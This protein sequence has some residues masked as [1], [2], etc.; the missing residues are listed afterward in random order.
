MNLGAD[1]Q[2]TGVST[3]RIEDND[4]MVT[5]DTSGRVKMFNLSKVDF[6]GPGTHK[7]KEA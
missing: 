5:S 3:T 1:D 4:R 2:L 7:E 6:K